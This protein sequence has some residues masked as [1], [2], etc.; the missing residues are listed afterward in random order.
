MGW[1]WLAGLLEEEEL[2]VKL[3]N[4]YN[5]YKVK[6]I[7]ESTIKTDKIDAQLERTNFLPV[8]YLAPKEI[9]ER[10]EL[11]RHRIILVRLRASLKSRIH[12]ILAKRGIV[13]E[14]VNTYLEL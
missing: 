14:G 6:L 1:E 12:S 7:A 5:P 9:R 3:A 2:K 4:P 8:S 11:L 10:R 13:K